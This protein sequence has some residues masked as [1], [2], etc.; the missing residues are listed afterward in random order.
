MT[1]HP[2]ETI[3]RLSDELLS[4]NFGKVDYIAGTGMSGVLPL[5]GVHIKTHIPYVVIR[6]PNDN[7]HSQ[8]QRFQCSGTPWTSITKF[9]IIDDLVD[10]GSTVQRIIETLNPAKCAGILLYQCMPTFAKIASEKFVNLPISAFTGN[11]CNKIPWR[12]KCPVV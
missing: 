6:K 5:V 8:I 3:D 9:V 7:N 11:L 4:G 1:N 10:S 12:S 2:K